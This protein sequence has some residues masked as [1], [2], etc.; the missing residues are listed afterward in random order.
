MH[1]VSDRIPAASDEGLDGAM[2]HVLADLARVGLT[3]VHSMD[4]ARGFV[5]LQRL[6]EKGEL[7]VR[8]TYNIPVA[9]LP[10]A[11]RIGLRSGWGD[12]S[13]RFWGVKAFLDGSVGSRTAEMLDG[14]GT[15]RLAQSDLAGPV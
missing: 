15:A 13:L 4:S 3:G 10:Q 11:E 2:S 14:S 8:V 7:A 6:R 5:S 1:L 9:D 12:P